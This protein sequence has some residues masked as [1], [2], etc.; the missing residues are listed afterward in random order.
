MATNAQSTQIARLGIILK[1]LFA[2]ARR[3]W[4]GLIALSILLHFLVWKLTTE[5]AASLPQYFHDLY[6]WNV[7]DL[8]K[9]FAHANFIYVI[10]VVVLQAA[11][12]TLFA[13]EFESGRSQASA[14]SAFRQGIRGLR[15]AEF[16]FD[17][18]RSLAV[19]WR[20]CWF[21]GFFG[22]LAALVVF[23]IEWIWQAISGNEVDFINH[24]VGVV[25]VLSTAAHA[26][27]R[28]SLA[29]PITI[30][31]E[32]SAKM[33]MK[34]SRQ[35]T[36][37]KRSRATIWFCL[38]AWSPILALLFLAALFEIYDNVGGIAMWFILTAAI[39]LTSLMSA[40]CYFYVRPGRLPSRRETG[41]KRPSA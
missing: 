28:C 22:A 39:L 26:L 17:V 3:H 4:R 5:F 36:S 41:A 15:A 40:G 23:G 24:P 16:F 7:F 13:R 32:I 18:G 33:S 29:I 25:L 12:I 6:G 31:E 21:A 27:L 10:Y 14:E 11:L 2:S 34:R 20:M 37:F 19:L 9:V 1:A 30:V 8:E 38:A 35:W